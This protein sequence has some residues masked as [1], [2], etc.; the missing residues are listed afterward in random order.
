MIKCIIIDDELLAV[1]LIKKYLEKFTEIEIVET[2]NNG[3]EGLKAINIHKPQL[4][5]LDIQMPKISGF[6]MLEL[7]ENPPS[8][9]F[10]TAFEQ[11]ALQAFEK[12]AIHYLL[13]PYSQENFNN[14]V[15]KF[16]AQYNLNAAPIIQ[17][18]ELEN[19]KVEKIVLKENNE[20]KILQLHDISH[21][22]AYDDYVKIHHKEKTFLKKKT[23]SYYEKSLSNKQFVRVHR[24]ILLNIDYLSKIELYNKES[25]TAF[26]KNQVQVTVSKTGYQNLKS[27]LKLN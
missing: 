27:I 13:K 2:C 9:I 5:F 12:N 16:L 7:L 4:I 24:S 3:F 19:E 10:S 1:E 11:Y 17:S 14:A 15:N 20:I 26:L 6:E 8:V 18:I 23:L 22:E 21:I 25:Y